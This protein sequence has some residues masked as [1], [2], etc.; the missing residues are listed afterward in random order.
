MRNKDDRIHKNKLKTM[1]QTRWVERHTSMKDFDTMYC[2]LIECLDAIANNDGGHWGAKTIT[3]TNGLLFNIT[4]PSFI[5]AFKTNLYFFGYTKHMSINLQGSTMDV[6]S[7]YRDIK[8]TKIVIHDIRSDPEKE[9]KPVYDSMLKMADIAGKSGLPGQQTLR[10]NIEAST[11]EEYWRRGIFVPFLDH[12]ISEFEE[13]FGQLSQDA[14]LG[15]NLLPNEVGSLKPEDEAAIISHYKDDL[16]SPNTVVQELHRWKALWNGQPDIPTTLAET[17]QSS[18][19]STKS[20]PNISTI[21][22]ILS[23]TPVTFAST[24]RANSALKYIKTSKRLM[25]GPDRLN[26]L[27]LLYVH[28]DITINHDTIVDLYASRCLGSAPTKE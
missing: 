9:F 17:L 10:N 25:M 22:H 2:P 14:I 24:E 8:A 26:A 27:L 1:C 18:Q 28:R 19:F 12:L 5:A 21:L 23:I 13:R 20:Y 15:L 16:S 3:E 4:T 11:S 7:A 6:I